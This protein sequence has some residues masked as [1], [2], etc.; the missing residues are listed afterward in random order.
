[1][2]I[3]TQFYLPAYNLYLT[4]SLFLQASERKLPPP[5]WNPTPREQLL[6]SIRRGRPLKHIQQAQ[7]G[8]NNKLLISLLLLYSKEY[9]VCDL[10]QQMAMNY[11]LFIAKSIKTTYL[12]TILDY[13]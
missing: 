8:E 6:D 5:K 2:Y 10:K 1:M 12:F 13:V 11:K 7:T 3:I 4:C 9:A